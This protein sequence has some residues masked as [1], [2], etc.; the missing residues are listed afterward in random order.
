MNKELDGSLVKVVSP[1][2]FILKKGK[3]N[4]AGFSVL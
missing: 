4:E 2:F 1:N 3:K